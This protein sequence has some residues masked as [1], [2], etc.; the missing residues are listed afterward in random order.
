M[1]DSPVTSIEA[2]SSPSALSNAAAAVRW[3][4]D[5][6]IRDRER[7]AVEAGGYDGEAVDAAELPGVIC[8]DAQGRTLTATG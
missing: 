2:N 5:G 3:D 8:R 4:R 1:P 7:R 6:V